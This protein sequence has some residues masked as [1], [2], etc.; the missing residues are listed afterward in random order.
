MFNASP[1]EVLA[2]RGAL[3]H[4]KEKHPNIIVWREKNQQSLNPGFEEL[5]NGWSA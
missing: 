1:C 2:Q 3:K 5:G 4:R